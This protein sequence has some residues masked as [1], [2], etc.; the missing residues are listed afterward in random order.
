[1]PTLDA[2][3][4]PDEAYVLVEVDWTSH[5]QV[6]YATV[7]RRNT[8]TGEIV[9]LR[10]YVAFDDTGALLLDCSLGLWWDTEPPLNVPLE[11]CTVASAVDTDLSQN[12]DFETTTAPWSGTG[13]TLTQDATAAKVGAFSLR[14]TTIGGTDNPRVTQSGI[15]GILAGETVTFSAWVKTSGTSWN[16]VR[17]EVDVTYVDLLTET[18]VSPIVMV[19]S[20]TWRFI[21]ASFVA[22]SDISTVTL[23]F[24]AMGTPTVGVN[25]QI[26]EFRLSHETTLADT[27]CETVTVDSE[28]VWLKN[29]TSPCLDVEVGLCDPMLEDCEA[30]DRVTYVGLGEDEFSPNTVLLAPANRKNLLPINRVRRGPANTLTLL[31]HTCDASDALEAINAP[32]NDLLFQVPADYCIPDRYMSVGVVA[33]TYISVDQRE[34]FRLFV[35]PHVSVDRPPGPSNGVCGARIMDLCDIYSS[36]SALNI[37]GLTWTDLLLGLA[38]PDGPGQPEP[39]AGARTWA[40]VEAEFTDWADV[41]NGGTRDWQELRD[42][43]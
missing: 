5:P 10:P 25:F 2:T 3:V 24:E 21:Q 9:T 6:E 1:M 7:T 18:F 15:T 20:T 19:E 12:P 28:S 31:A 26:D 41:E 33:K 8:V 16:G 17:L 39:P 11:Y 40:D 42:G 38:S 14:A 22:T 27:A 30:A 29:P 23:A 37:A 35:M 34:D 32:G 13:F 43:L 4:F 36:W